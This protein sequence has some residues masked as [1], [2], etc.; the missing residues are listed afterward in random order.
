MPELISVMGAAWSDEILSWKCLVFLIGRPRGFPPVPV[1]VD[2][3]T[4]GPCGSTGQE[5]EF[6]AVSRCCADVRV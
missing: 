2:G 5:M 6:A 3:A 4:E 1:M